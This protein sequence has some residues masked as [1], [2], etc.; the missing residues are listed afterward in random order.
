MINEQLSGAQQVR[1]C[2][3]PSSKGFIKNMTTF[4]L[5]F[6]FT[7][8]SCSARSFGFHASFEAIE[9]CEV[10]DKIV[11]L[12]SKNIIFEIDNFE[13]LLSSSSFV[14]L[15]RKYPSFTCYWWQICA[16]ICGFGC[17][18][19]IIANSESLKTSFYLQWLKL[20]FLLLFVAK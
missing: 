9:E 14:C 1:W 20:C 13:L 12:V 10:I 16:L 19:L 7:P 8:S 6:V 3:A 17:S 15:F 4:K 5:L 2:Q 11:S 18:H